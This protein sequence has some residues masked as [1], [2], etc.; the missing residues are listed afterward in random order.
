M[1]NPIPLTIIIYLYKM[2]KKHQKKYIYKPIPESG[3]RFPIL[4]SLISSAIIIHGAVFQDI[5]HM[6]TENIRFNN[7]T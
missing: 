6:K 1:C 4:I 2:H 5:L 3:F 7:G